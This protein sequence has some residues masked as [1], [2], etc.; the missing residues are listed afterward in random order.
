[1]TVHVLAIIASEIGDRDD[2]RSL[3]PGDRAA[4]F[5]GVTLAGADCRVQVPIDDRAAWSFA[6]AVGATCERSC[7]RLKSQPDLVLIGPGAINRF[8]DEFAG[9][10]A[11]Q[12]SA[13]L[14]FDV[15]QVRREADEWRVVCDAGR[16]GQDILSVLGPLV[17]VVSENAQRPPYVSRYR[18]TQSDRSVPIAF[19]TTAPNTGWKPA[20]PRAPRSPSTTAAN[21][22]SRANAAFGIETDSGRSRDQTIVAD[23]PAVCAQVLLRYLLHHGFVARALTE[24]AL[25]VTPQT[26]RPKDSPITNAAPAVACRRVANGAG[27]R[28]P[29]RPEDPVQ[30]MDRR[31]RSTSETPA[32]RERI[33]PDR[34]QR[35]PRRLDTSNVSIQRGPF[36]VRADWQSHQP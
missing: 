12:A 36:P 23:E 22:E 9:R 3:L 21:A 18:L 6:T 19:Q 4:A 27:R 31:P 33:V 5:W 16:G 30:R 26:S 25:E 24:S 34:L 1:M 20:T 7:D 13:E 29:R 10:L 15:L 11:E 17:L 32:S 8:G 2:A 35:Q 28:G 14:L